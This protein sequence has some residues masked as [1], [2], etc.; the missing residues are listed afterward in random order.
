MPVEE[1]C[2]SLQFPQIGLGVFTWWCLLADVK[3]FAA[4][5]FSTTGLQCSELGCQELRCFEC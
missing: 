4:F 3:L 2:L 5:F 1:L